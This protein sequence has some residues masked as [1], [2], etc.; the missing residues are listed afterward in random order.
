MTRQ[1]QAFLREEVGETSTSQKHLRETVDE[2]VHSLLLAGSFEIYIYEND[3]IYF[4]LP[5]A[6][7]SKFL[8]LKSSPVTPEKKETGRV[9]YVRIS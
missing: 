6:H 3:S 8:V 9:N 4:I 7:I 5:P 2:V 1:K